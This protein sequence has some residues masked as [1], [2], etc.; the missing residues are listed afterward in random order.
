MVSS[1]P[2]RRPSTTV[3]NVWGSSRAASFTSSDLWDDGAPC[4]IAC[5]LQGVVTM[6]W[7]KQA[8]SRQHRSCACRCT[9]TQSRTACH[10]HMHRHAQLTMHAACMHAQAKL[11]HDLF[12]QVHHQPLHSTPEVFTSEPTGTP[13]FLDR[14]AVSV[15]GSKS[16][17]PL[18]PT[19][20]AST[21]CL[22]IL[23]SGLLRYP[24]QRFNIRNHDKVRAASMACQLLGPAPCTDGEQALAR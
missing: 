14:L 6:T 5:Q 3:S 23:L 12:S 21:L 15:Y 4:S 9:C 16:G 20:P 11:Q 8:P 13:T 10:A 7:G 17:L 18:C 22:S 24:A 19:L 2:P 1:P